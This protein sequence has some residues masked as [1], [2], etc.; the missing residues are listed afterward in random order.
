MEG[1]HSSHGSPPEVTGQKPGVESGT[2]RRELRDRNA[3]TNMLDP[4][5]T[6]VWT[7]RLG[8]ILAEQFGRE[9]GQI[10]LRYAKQMVQ[11]IKSEA[12]KNKR[13]TC[14]MFRRLLLADADKLV[15][16][17]HYTSLQALCGILKSGQFWLTKGSRNDSFEPST[18]DLWKRTYVGCFSRNSALLPEMWRKYG[19]R[20]NRSNIPICIRFRAKP[21][22]RLANDLRDLS[23]Q[24]TVFALDQDE[25]STIPVILEK[26]SFHDVASLDCWSEN[27][28][29]VPTNHVEP[30]I[31]VNLSKDE[32]IDDLAGF[33]KLREWSE[34]KEVRLVVTRPAQGHLPKHIAIP[35]TAALSSFA[36]RI[37]PCHDD[38]ATQKKLVESLEDIGFCTTPNHHSR[39]NH[40]LFFKRV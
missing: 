3:F 11:K 24:A 34:E 13:I 25:Q 18:S 19:T 35:S 5:A 22:R 29:S 2:A 39:W 7:K 9:H 37:E 31:F 28:H 33:W 26:S 12:P 36:V 20:G 17:F 6:I 21:I 30:L 10:P 8:R 40:W 32:E 14:K 16:V 38:L 4:S 1:Q 27:N 15:Y 23:D